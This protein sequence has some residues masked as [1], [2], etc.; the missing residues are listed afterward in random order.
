MLIWRHGRA[1]LLARRDEGASTLPTF[2]ASLGAAGAPPRVPGVAVYLTGQQ[3]VVPVA[4]SLNLRHMEW[5][6]ASLL[7]VTL[8]D[9]YV[10]L[11]ATGVIVDPTIVIRP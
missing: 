6:W 5:A 7:S 10:R 9:V 4:L 8:A 3:E 11:A 1:V 2:V